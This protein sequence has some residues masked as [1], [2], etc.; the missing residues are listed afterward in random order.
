MC[1][2][3]LALSPYAHILLVSILSKTKHQGSILVPTTLG[4]TEK[5]CH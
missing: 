4:Y 2:V 3:I 1:H 5:V